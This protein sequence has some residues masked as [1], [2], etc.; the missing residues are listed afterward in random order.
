MAAPGN[1]DSYA[2]DWWAQGAQDEQDAIW[3]GIGDDVKQ[4][5]ECALTYAQSRSDMTPELL[6]AGISRIFAPQ[7]LKRRHR[8]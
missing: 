2:Y 1:H 4:V 7:I 6:L 8:L 5:L 3:Q